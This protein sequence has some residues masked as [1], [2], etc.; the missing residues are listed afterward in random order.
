MIKLRAHHLICIPRFKYGGSYN[1]NIDNR[2]YQIQDKVK[3]NPNTTLKI[4]AKPDYICLSCPH[5]KNKKCMKRVG[6]H[7]RLI[8]FDKQI[9]KKLRI[10]T[11]STIKAKDAFLLSIEKI[12]NKQIKKMCK[13][14]EF[15][16]YCLKH[17]I[18]KSFIKK[19]K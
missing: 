10:K 3:K 19:V 6:I 15:Q 16:D 9:L 13:G 18:N 12:K 1:K 17:G 8:K 5:F 14:C 2:F 4:I 11:N 7:N